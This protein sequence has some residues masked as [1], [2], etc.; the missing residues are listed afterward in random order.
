MAK[1]GFRKYGNTKT[2]YKGIKFDSKKEAARY[3]DLLLLKLAGEISD[4]QL[5]YKYPI[6][7]GGVKICTYIADFTYMDKDGNKITEDSKGV[8][9]PEFRLKKK[10]MLA[11]YGIT[12]KLT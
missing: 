2:V 9:T 5:Q 8:Q 3:H 7:I 12:I 11:C 1:I 6:V 4:L 10:L